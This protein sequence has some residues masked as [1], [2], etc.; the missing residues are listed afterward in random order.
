MATTAHAD[1]AASL[2][3]ALISDWHAAVDGILQ[4]DS[5]KSAAFVMDKGEHALRIRGWL[6]L[7]AK[8]TIDVQ[9][10]IWSTDNVGRLALA[11][12]LHA[13]NRGVKVRILVDDLMLEKPYEL[14]LAMDAH[15]DIEI[16]VYNANNTLG[17]GFWKRVR[18][19]LTSFRSMNQRMHQKTFIVDDKAAVVGGRNMADEYYDF[20]PEFNFRDRD[21]LLAGPVV[22]QV[23]EGFSEHWNS[24][25]SVPVS[26]ILVKEAAALESPMV[27]SIGRE[28]LARWDD[29]AHF[30]PEMKQGILEVPRRVPDLLH[31][32]DLCDARYIHDV[33]GKNDGSHG[34]GGGGVLTSALA[35]L[36]DSAKQEVLIQSPYLILDPKALELL[37]SL[38]KRGV[39]IRISTNSAANNDNHY[40]VSGY[41]KQ[42]EQILAAGIEVHELKPHPQHQTRILQR[43]AQF[44][45]HPPIIV[46]HAKTAVIDRRILVVGTYN[47]DPRSQNLNTEAA[48]VMPS[49]KLA[50]EAASAIE[51]DMRAENS[52]DAK[53]GE[54]DRA[55][56][57]WQRF[58]LW[59]WR[60][61]PLEPI[62]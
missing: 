4:R 54:G 5:G 29:T 59:L 7:N 16:R 52:W 28:L 57:W 34:L 48:V 44:G 37:A 62:L 60:L 58:K 3:A 50:Q 36:L 26:T 38:V 40:A 6:G 56:S 25:L 13:A 46:L 55:L 45:E 51:E 2:E 49:T 42:R 61:V 17:V 35:A 20:D 39:K 8:R 32:M 27:D 30:S 11:G 53:T 47:L 14:L 19:A 10:F 23:H 15:P 33:P 12:L 41:Q 31:D 1:S 24:P 21:V 18:T 9:Y 22:D 43:Y